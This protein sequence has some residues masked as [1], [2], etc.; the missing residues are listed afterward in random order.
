MALGVDWWGTEAEYLLKKRNQGGILVGRTFADVVRKTTVWYFVFAPLT[1][2]YLGI[3]VHV[4]WNIKPISRLLGL[5]ENQPSA[6]LLDLCV[7]M[8]PLVGAITGYLFWVNKTEKLARN[9]FIAEFE[10]R[11]LV[12]ATTNHNLV[13]TVLTR[14]PDESIDKMQVVWTPDGRCA[15]GAIYE[16]IDEISVQQ[17]D[18]I[19]FRR[20]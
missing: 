7:V 20:P 3:A 10:G 1:V 8:L 12:Q 4:A 19:R 11:E 13:Y 14:G 9:E 18:A 6:L 15:N 17:F 2:L 5:P 16:N